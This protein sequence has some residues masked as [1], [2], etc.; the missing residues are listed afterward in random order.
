MLSDGEAEKLSLG[1]PEPVAVGGTRRSAPPASGHTFSRWGGASN[2]HGGVGRDDNLL[3]E[4]VLLPHDGVQGGLGLCRRRA[5]QSVEGREGEDGEL[6]GLEENDDR[7]ED[8]DESYGDSD[9]LV[10][11]KIHTDFL[12]RAVGEDEREDKR[13]RNRR[14]WISRITLRLQPTHS[15]TAL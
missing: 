2:V 7:D 9:E 15:R 6:T 13:R 10:L 5:S 8:D 4:L 12:L 11:I 14:R 1:E 3:R